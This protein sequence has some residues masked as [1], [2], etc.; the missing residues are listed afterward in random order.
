MTL[1]WGCRVRSTLHERRTPSAGMPI[2]ASVTSVLSEG[3]P[4]TVDRGTGFGIAR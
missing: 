3:C 2:T 1:Y 4:R